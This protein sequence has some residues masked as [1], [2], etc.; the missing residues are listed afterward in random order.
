MTYSPQEGAKAPLGV[1]DI[2][3]RSFSIFFR[4]LPAILLI[5]FVTS[6]LSL[7][8]S[9]LL[10]GWEMTLGAG[11]P[12][13]ADFNAFAFALNLLLSMVFYAVTI[14]LMVQLAYDASL[15]RPT[16][17]TAYVNDAVRNI[18]PIAVM[19]TVVSLLVG[20]GSLLIV[21]GIWL[22]A[23][24]AVTIPAIV[25]ERAGFS[26]MSRSQDLTKDYRWPIAGAM[27]L[28]LLLGLVATFVVGI[29]IGLIGA[30]SG[31]IIVFALIL[32]AIG[33]AF[34]YALV[35]IPVALIYARLREIK[36]GVGMDDLVKVFD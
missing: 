28:M 17:I 23:V 19:A 6:L 29:V 7:L 14:S 32:A 9:G 20:L 1:G 26:A 2:V 22:Y 25:I 4:K 15:G 8:V 12:N 11:D 5:G 30:L 31:A 18:F 3:S 13:F 35:S 10:I 21:P 24:Y 16:R 27:I 36:E 33:S 34:T